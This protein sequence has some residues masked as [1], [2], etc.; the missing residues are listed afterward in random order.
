ML[1]LG[2]GGATRT[3][4]QTPLD[5]DPAVTCQAIIL[6]GDLGC[7]SIHLFLVYFWILLVDAEL[8]VPM[9]VWGASA[10]LVNPRVV[11]RVG[12]EWLLQAGT[13]AARAR[14]WLRRPSRPCAQLFVFVSAAGFDPDRIRSISRLGNGQ[15][16][17]AAGTRYRRRRTA[18][19]L[20]S[21]RGSGL[22]V[23]SSAASHQAFLA[24]P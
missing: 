4:S 20:S 23:T 8:M 16:F 10:D 22:A 21:L 2:Q 24:S 11:A 14:T 7:N 15:S 3:V 12:S 6:E 18:L 1:G 9:P 5:S 17:R 19:R 13:F